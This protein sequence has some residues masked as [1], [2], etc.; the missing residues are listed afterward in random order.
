[1]K[2]PA[3]HV[4]LALSIGLILNFA[5]AQ[6]EESTGDLYNG[7]FWSGLHHDGKFLYVLALRDG[8]R[9]FVDV[10]MVSGQLKNKRDIEKFLKWW[11]SVY[12]GWVSP[13]NTLEMVS[14]LDSFYSESANALIPIVIA[15]GYVTKQVEGTREEELRSYLEIQ[16]SYWLKSYEKGTR[17]GK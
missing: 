2:R 16:R 7:R 14:S 17:D 15:A 11:T 1:M 8:M 13:L 4:L 5:E 9:G 10:S 12:N 6:T 3:R